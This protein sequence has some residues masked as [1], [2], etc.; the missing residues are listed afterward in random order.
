VS[1]LQSSTDSGQY[2]TLPM[3]WLPVFF[4]LGVIACESTALMSGAN[5]GHWLLNLCHSLWGQTDDATFQ[6]THFLLRKLGHFTG[7]GLLSL[8][9]RR[10]W[11]I[12]FRRTWKGQRSRLPFSAAALA[13]GCTFAV[14]CLDEWHQSFLPG[15]TST[16]YDVMIDTTGAL[17]FNLALT[18]YMTRRR[19]ALVERS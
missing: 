4:G 12:T 17:L 19:R 10:A 1:Y 18:A 8:L 14:A 6:T 11:L 7:Y 5:T 15:R 2:P 9:F 13:V 16:P 3:A